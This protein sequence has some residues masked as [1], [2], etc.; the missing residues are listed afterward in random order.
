MDPNIVGELFI[1]NAKLK[2]QMKE[3]KMDKRLDLFYMSGLSHHVELGEV[4]KLVM[5]LPHG[6][7]CVESGF[8]P[9]KEMFVENMSEGSLV[10]Q[11]MVFSGVMNEGG[12]LM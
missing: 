9:N 1:A 12:L 6:N 7:A 3:F 11:R 8:S 10:A 4:V 5:I 2:N